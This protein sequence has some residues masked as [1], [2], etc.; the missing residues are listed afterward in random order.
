M[1]IGHH[2]AL[3]RA[4]S[5]PHPRLFERYLAVLGV[6]ERRP[7]LDALAELLA[8]HLARIPFEN[9]SKLR[10]RHGRSEQ[11]LPSLARYLDGIERWGLGGT[12]YANNVHL[13]ELLVHLGY[14]AA[15]C[16]ADMS[17]PDVHA[18][19]VVSLGGCRYLADAGYAAPLV[20]PL[21]IDADETPEIAWGPFRYTFHP[22]G[23]DGRPMLEMDRGDGRTHGY[24]VNLRPRRA[25]DFTGV[26]ADSYRPEATFMNA[27]LVS[28]Y[29]APR[30]AMLRNLVLIRGSAA[31]AE[32][33]P[34]ASAADLPAVI[35]LEFGIPASL[36]AEALDGV[37]LTTSL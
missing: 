11:R 4:Q 1:A 25:S 10:G 21:P 31:S 14:D 37:S 9:L 5:M 8:A 15:L 23:P 18:V 26:I 20:E 24:R 6:S 16:G 22:T 17:M 30:W 27:V 36:V 13:H 3:A 2:P 33:T 32:V 7:S 29:G 35:E 34:I 19:N 12:C 28:K